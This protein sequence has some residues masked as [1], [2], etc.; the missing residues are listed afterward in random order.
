MIEL[1]KKEMKVYKILSNPDWYSYGVN[2]VKRTVKID[3][4]ELKEISISLSK[5]LNDKV[6]FFGYNDVKYMGFESRRLDYERDKKAGVNK[7]E[8]LISQGVYDCDLN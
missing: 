1:T 8:K 7:V 5:K 4:S 3:S 2:L 6:N